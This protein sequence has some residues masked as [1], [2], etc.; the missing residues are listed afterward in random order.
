MQVGE[1]EH[2]W[3]LRLSA[4]SRLVTSAPAAALGEV[5]AF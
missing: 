5:I 2:P 3:R 4:A 1:Q